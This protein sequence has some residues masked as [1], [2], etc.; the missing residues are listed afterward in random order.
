[1]GVDELRLAFCQ[2]TVYCERP[3]TPGFRALGTPGHGFVPVC[4]ALGHLALARGPVGFFSLA[5]ADLLGLL[6]GPASGYRILLD[7]AVADVLLLRRAVLCAPGGR[8]AGPTPGRPRAE[9]MTGISYQRIHDLPF[10][11]DAGRRLSQPTRSSWE[12]W[13]D[14]A[15]GRGLGRVSP[16]MVAS[17]LA[18]RR[19]DP[20]ADPVA[21]PDRP[22][23]RATALSLLGLSLPELRRRYRALGGTGSGDDPHRSSRPDY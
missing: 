11:P 20:E 8:P 6:D 22:G 16:A 17:A 14:G 10:R 5:G 15:G 2:A 1:M 7:L 18:D 4:S 9:V 12:S 3:A 19:A 21:D 23:R 13:I